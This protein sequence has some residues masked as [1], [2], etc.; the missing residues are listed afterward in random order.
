MNE[1]IASLLIVVGALFM[2]L[3][4]VGIVR[5]PDLFTRMQA[6]SK[7]STLGV[8]ALLLAVA[9]HFMRL[10]ITSRALVTVLFFFLTAPVTAHLVARAAYF[11]GVP[12]WAGTII[13]ELRDKYDPRT[14][15]CESRPVAHAARPAPA[16]EHGADQR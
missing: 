13:D 10:G 11:V 12:L 9:V 14:G 2:L 8:S 3:A 6:A 15:R 16:T 5:M 7:A 1:I 4:A